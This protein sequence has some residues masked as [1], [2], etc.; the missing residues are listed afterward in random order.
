M[1]G[2]SPM[3]DVNQNNGSNVISV[4]TNSIAMFANDGTM[5][6]FSFKNDRIIFTITPR[7]VDESTGKQKWPKDLGH[8]AILPPTTAATFYNAIMSN[9]YD[10]IREGRDHK[11]FL[12]VPLNRDCT[13]LI[14]LSWV[15]NVATL[16][17]FNNVNADR[18]CTNIHT[19][20]FQITTS[21]DNYDP[22]SGNFMVKEVQGQLYLFIEILAAFDEAIGGAYAHSVKN[23]QNYNYNQ[24]MN[25]L[26]AIAIKI[27]ASVQTNYTSQYGNASAFSSGG[28]DTVN[29]TTGYQES[30]MTGHVPQTEVETISSLQD[31]LS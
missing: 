1:K 26:K 15:N 4:S 20:Q 5:L 23:I 3:S 22:Q 30:A 10:E 16:A 8:S 27:G 24:I 12:T 14:G 11:G 13:A 25:H 31:M 18:T 29:Y 21:I 6:K 17:I 9:L 2:V 19:F 28:N 7:I